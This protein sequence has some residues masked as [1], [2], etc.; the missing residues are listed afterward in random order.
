[1]KLVI[2]PNVLVKGFIERHPSYDALIDEIE[3]TA[4]S[5]N[6]R[7][8]PSIFLSYATEDCPKVI[9][10]YENLTANKFNPW[11]DKKDLVPG[12]CWE[13][14]VADAIQR[15]TIFVA[16]LSQ[17]AVTKLSE[18]SP[19]SAYKYALRDEH[20][21]ALDFRKKLSHRSLPIVPFFLE[22][23]A[24]PDELQKYH[25]LEWDANIG[26]EDNCSILRNALTKLLS[27]CSTPNGASNVFQ[28]CLDNEGKI[29]EEYDSRLS[30]LRD[31]RHWRTLLKSNGVICADWSGLPEACVVDLSCLRSEQKACYI[32]AQKSRGF[33]IEECVP[34][35]CPT[36][37]PNASQSAIDEALRVRRLSVNTAR[38]MLE[39]M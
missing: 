2:D 22:D 3:R 34:T 13:E 16:F 20:K 24:F 6:A 5:T 28:M 12:Y 18:G 10:I 9:E 35:S 1:M 27:E 23:C 29:N 4:R 37:N 38:Y 21:M 17:K 8:G 30:H 14:K 25:R 7:S 32:V 39:A 11:M 36:C 33:L 31:Y 19:Q 26:S 15:S